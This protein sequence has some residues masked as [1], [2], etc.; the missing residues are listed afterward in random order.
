MYFLLIFLILISSFGKAISND[1]FF[2]E[3]KQPEGFI[4]TK[5][6]SIGD[7]YIIVSVKNPQINAKINN[8]GIVNCTK[9]AIIHWAYPVTNLTIEF[10]GDITATKPFT[11]CIV[12]KQLKIQYKLY[13]SVNDIWT[14]VQ[15]SVL[16]VCLKSE[17]GN[18]IMIKYEHYPRA[19]Q[20]YEFTISYTIEL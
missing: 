1:A 13:K 11:L 19:I 9:T 5:Y 15:P 6:T 14:F 10:Y 4:N 7:C 18:K 20:N 17:L 3:D 16:P 2:N 8:I 12:N